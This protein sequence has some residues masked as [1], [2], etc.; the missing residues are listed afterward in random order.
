MIRGIYLRKGINYHGLAVTLILS[1]LNV[2]SHFLCCKDRMRLVLLQKWTSKHCVRKQT[3]QNFSE[4]GDHNFWFCREVIPKLCFVVSCCSEDLLQVLY[5]TKSTLNLY[6]LLILYFFFLF[7]SLFLLEERR[8]QRQSC[9]CAYIIK[10]HA[11]NPYKEV[12]ASY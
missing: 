5:H 2:V 4:P 11:T 10:D 6:V 3:P 8:V 12:E 1:S 9:P 7:L